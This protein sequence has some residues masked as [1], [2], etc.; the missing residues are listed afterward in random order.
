MHYFLF[1]LY[2]H[3]KFHKFSWDTFQ[4]IARSRRTDV[5]ADDKSI[6]HPVLSCSSSCTRSDVGFLLR[7]QL[8]KHSSY[9]RTSTANRVAVFGRDFTKQCDPKCFVINNAR[10]LL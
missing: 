8:F 4:V 1:E 9:I 3:A 7:M 2:P 6:V 10:F 5:R